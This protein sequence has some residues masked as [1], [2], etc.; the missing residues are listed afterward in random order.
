MKFEI[1]NDKKRNKG[2]KEWGTVML[3][4]FWHE[5]WG[6]AVRLDNLFVVDLDWKVE[7]E[8][9]EESKGGESRD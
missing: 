8:D 3:D 4:N 1:Y 9:E 7:E 5:R 6:G 2:K